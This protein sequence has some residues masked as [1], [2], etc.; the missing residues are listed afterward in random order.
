[1]SW[2]CRTAC[3][4]PGGKNPTGTAGT[5]TTP[6]QASP[7]SAATAAPSK[8]CAAASSRR[9]SACNQYD[10]P[11]VTA[12]HGKRNMNPEPLT[13]ALQAIDNLKVALLSRNSGQR[14]ASK[15]VA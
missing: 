10:Y 15:K 14:A 11:A 4:A 9:L 2:T 1:M 8:A 12:G 13:A 3:A 6:S 7:R 5:A